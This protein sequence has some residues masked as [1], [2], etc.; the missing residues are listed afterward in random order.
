[1]KAKAV[2]SM[3]ES[4]IDANL[5]AL[6]DL[7]NQLKE[8]TSE[9]TT[10]LRRADMF[11]PQTRPVWSQGVFSSQILLLP[12]ALGN[13][14]AKVDQVF[15]VY[16]G[17]ARI[18]SIHDALTRMLEMRIMVNQPDGFRNERERLWRQCADII[19]GLIKTGN[20]LWEKTSDGG[21]SE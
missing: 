1:M 17:L 6:V 4:E 18:T 20:P 19:S 10:D 9:E 11:L 16:D 3:L 12:L 8:G 14:R 7:R 13:D 2:R 21:R 5:S 15:R